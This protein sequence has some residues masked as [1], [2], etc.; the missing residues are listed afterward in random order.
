MHVV[1]LK[2]RKPRATNGYDESSN[3]QQVYSDLLP[4]KKKHSGIKA[5]HHRRI[6]VLASSLSSSALGSSRIGL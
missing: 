3:V 5:K 2:Y 1:R 6:R 4:T